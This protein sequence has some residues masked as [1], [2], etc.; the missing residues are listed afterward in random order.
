MARQRRFLVRVAVMQSDI[1]GVWSPL[2]RRTHGW[3]CR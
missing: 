1:P 2:H 3:E